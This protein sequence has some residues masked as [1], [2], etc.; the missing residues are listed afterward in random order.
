MSIARSKT[1]IGIIGLYGSGKTT[2]TTALINHLK[3]HV[4]EILPINKGATKIIFDSEHE[5]SEGYHKFD[6]HYN[7]AGLAHGSFPKKTKAMQQYRCT[8]YR[9]DWPN[10]KCDLTLTDIAGEKFVDIG[11]RGISYAQ[12]SEKTLHFLTTDPEY[13]E[14]TKDYIAILEKLE[15]TESEIILSYKDLLNRLYK[16]FRPIITPS[17]FLINKA[18]DFLGC[19]VRKG[20]L[21]RSFTGLTEESQF[22]PLPKELLS[23]NKDLFN[24]FEKRFIDYQREI[25]DPLYYALRNCNELVVLVDVTTILASNPGCFRGNKYILDELF[26]CLQPGMGSLGFA[27]DIAKMIFAL[28]HISQSQVTKIAVI[29]TKADKVLQ[30]HTDNLTGLLRD[31]V[32]PI[33]DLHQ[34]LATVL[35]IKYF[36][37]AS[38]K[39]TNT[40]LEGKL[41]GRL[42]EKTYLD[43]KQQSLWTPSEVPVRWPE[44]WNQGDFNFP[45]TKAKF[46]KS[47]IPIDHINMEE[48]MEYLL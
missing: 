6:Y 9:D 10:T 16:N 3:N 8:F 47:G 42:A 43:S 45:D 34:H 24:S 38:V 20:A 5:P 35:K 13:A 15:S 4:P 30:H 2:F 37:C 33:L 48:V 18:G 22:A 44:D 27:W 29:A 39:S 28:G 26:K 11:M 21:D 23:L 12:W 1:H 14:Y 19:D 25:V 17:T 31:M 32:S 40:T 41:Q 7:M 36:G 46:T